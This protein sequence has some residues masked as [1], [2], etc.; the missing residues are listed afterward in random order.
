MARSLS[1]LIRT[2]GIGDMATIYSATRR[3]N[4]AFHLAYIPD[5]FDGVPG[6]PFDREYMQRLFTLGYQMAR[7]GYPRV[8]GP[9]ASDRSRDE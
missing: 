2:Q 8:T 3:D 4:V 9:E 6:E 1:S 5:S 7:K